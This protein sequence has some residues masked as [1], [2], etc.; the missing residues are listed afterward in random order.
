MFPE[1]FR[2]KKWS[3]SLSFKNHNSYSQTVTKFNRMIS[4]SIGWFHLT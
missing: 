3:V 2:A 1:Q 4:K